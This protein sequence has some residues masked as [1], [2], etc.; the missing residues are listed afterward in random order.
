MN[1]NFLPGD[2]V[3]GSFPAD[4]RGFVTRFTGTVV[5][6]DNGG[7]RPSGLVVVRPLTRRCEHPSATEL[8]RNLPAGDIFAIEPEYLEKISVPYDPYNTI[9]S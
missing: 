7:L 2:H 3:G 9:N 8:G 4:S 5:M 1:E 6:V